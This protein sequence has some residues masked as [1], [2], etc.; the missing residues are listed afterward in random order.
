MWRGLAAHCFGIFLAKYPEKMGGAAN[1]S[2]KQIAKCPEANG[3]AWKC[4]FFGGNFAK[5]P[6]ANWGGLAA[7]FWNRRMLQR[8]FWVSYL[9]C[10]SVSTDFSA[11]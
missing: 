6:E 5:Y 9:K 8:T 2:G 3:G 1:F 11:S 4:N 10:S 7:A